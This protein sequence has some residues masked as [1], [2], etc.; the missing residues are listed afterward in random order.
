MNDRISMFRSARLSIYPP[1]RS[2]ANCRW[3]LLT[4]V[5]KRGIPTG[6]I[7]QDGI[8]GSAPAMPNEAE[9]VMLMDAALAQM[10]LP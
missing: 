8:I 3:A 7:I 10:R 9:I 5:V 2:G 4:T 6:Q 1:L